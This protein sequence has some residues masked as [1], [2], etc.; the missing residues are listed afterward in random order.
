M[1]CRILSVLFTLNLN[2]IKM[3]SECKEG[4]RYVI[5]KWCIIYFYQIGSIYNSLILNPNRF[6]FAFFRS[7]KNRNN[8]DMAIINLIR[9]AL[10]IPSFPNSYFFNL[11][12]NFPSKAL[13]SFLQKS[14]NIPIPSPII[15]NRRNGNDGIG[16]CL[17]LH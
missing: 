15:Q 3:N 16:I 17:V 7:T 4:A 6:N 5:L 14:L 11:G 12:L 8:I 10:R 13:K 1:I 9:I 2:I